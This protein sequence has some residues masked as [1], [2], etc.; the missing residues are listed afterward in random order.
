MLKG[1]NIQ[2]VAAVGLGTVL[3]LWAAGFTRHSDA[4]QQGQPGERKPYNVIFMVCD[5]EAYHLFAKDDFQLPA[6]KAIAKHGVTFKNHY[7]SSAICT[8]SRAVFLTGTAPQVNGVFDQMMFGYVPNL[9]PKIPT[10]GAIFKDMGYSTAYFG[11]FE[12]N[13]DLLRAKKTDNTST[14]LQPYGFDVY[15]SDGDNAGGPLGGYAADSYFGAEGVRWLREHAPGLRAKRQPF[16]MVTSFVNPHDVMFADCNVRGE[17]PP[18]Q[19]ALLPSAL[20]PPPPDAI[21][22]RKWDFTLPRSLQESLKAPGLP[23]ALG[24]YD[25]GWSGFFGV[26]PT[27]RKDMWHSYYNYYL[28][29]LRDNDRSIQQI[30]DAMNDLDLWKD[31]VVILTSD[32]GEMAGAHGGLRGK[33]PMCYEANAHVPLLIAHPEAKAGTSCGALTCHMD[34][35]PTFVSLAG[36][37][38]DKVPA[39]VKK[40]AGCDF[41]GLINDPEKADLHK[42]RPAV[43]YNYVGL[44][45]VDS[46]FLT[47]AVRGAVEGK[48][49]PPVKDINLDKR[50]FLLFVF[51]GRYKLGRFYAP[52]TFNT[53]QTLDQL[54]K[55][56]DVQLFDL[57]EDPDEMR[58]LA[59][60][61]EKHREVI[62][63]L[64]ALLNE[65]T[66][67]EIGVN[68]GS[69]LP[70]AAR[71]KKTTL[72]PQFDYATPA[73]AQAL[74]WLVEL[75][76]HDRFDERYNM[77][78]ARS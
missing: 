71:P 28:N 4:A 69:F 1:G 51:D 25:R 20:R 76:P 8:P 75:D 6:R 52:S 65:F 3:G 13:L 16:F 22:E 67:K 11:K 39:V 24:E 68:D 72:K 34:L 10:V 40:R 23:A 19:K 64:N 74:H 44:S 32:H 59:L 60:E 73:G 33:G 66:A 41:A 27:D 43:L 53:P 9:P 30:V 61:P 2:A 46:N 49:A 42:V 14:A 58:N 77:Q 18:V 5:Q 38:E 21:Y 45:S 36:V 48:G 31:T 70:E 56:N 55:F 37:P 17:K 29:C 50:G 63:R 15:N 47:P 12:C 35:L 26:I 54:F 7:I 62:L 57:K 78:S